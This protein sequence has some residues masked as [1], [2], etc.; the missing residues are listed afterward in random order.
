MEE[1]RILAFTKPTITKNM[2][3][4]EQLTFCKKCTNR[5]MDMQQGIICSLTGEK[6]NFENECP[7]FI[8]DESVKIELNDSEPL[9]QEEVK[10]SLSNEVLEK[11]RLEQNLPKAIIAGVGVGL[12]GAILW[13]LIT[14]ATNYQIG[15]MAIAIGAGVG[16]SMRFFGKGID[17][18]FGIAGG[19]IAVL[20][21]FIGN[22]LG[23][24]GFYANSEGLEF[25]ET[26]FLFD[27]TYFFPVMSETFDFMDIVFYGIA[28]YEGYKFSFRTF[29]EAE[30]ATLK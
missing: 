1:N 21:C 10:S 20:S 4:E 25:F 14:V 19:A 11:L 3:R 30:I 6:A 9:G 13:G 5:K 28:G 18:V 17:P 8:L 2:T 15:Y 7:D 23:I 24:I 12:I 29:T 26:L 27:Y 16:F 22:F